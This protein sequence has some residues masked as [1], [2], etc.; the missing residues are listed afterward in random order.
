MKKITEDLTFDEMSAVMSEILNG[1]HKDEE[2]AEFRE[3]ILKKIEDAEK[4]FK[5]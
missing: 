1:K 2:L 3:L 5:P 4:D